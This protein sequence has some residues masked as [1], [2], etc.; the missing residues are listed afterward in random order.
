MKFLRA[1][2]FVRLLSREWL[3]FFLFWPF[4]LVR[5]RHV[6]LCGG[7]MVV[8]GIIFLIVPVDLIGIVRCLFIIILNFRATTQV[9]FLSIWG[10]S[11]SLILIGI[12]HFLLMSWWFI[13][14]RVSQHQ[15]VLLL[16]Y[17]GQNII[18]NL[19]RNNST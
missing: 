9:R 6:I 8:I 1:N 3:T 18:Y 13:F 16:F 14:L 10:T 4:S 7:T 11:K 2:L 17:F 12:R 15:C 5:L 19:L